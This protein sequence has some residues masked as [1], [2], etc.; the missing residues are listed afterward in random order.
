MDKHLLYKGNNVEIRYDL[1][2]VIYGGNEHFFSRV[3]TQ[4]GWIWFHD[5][6]DT[7]S[8]CIRER[9]LVEVLD[10]GWLND[11][12]TKDVCEPLIAIYARA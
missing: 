9:N 12:D 4:D 6:R 8:V 10:L 11:K 3:V 5:G 7:G 2:G 1:R